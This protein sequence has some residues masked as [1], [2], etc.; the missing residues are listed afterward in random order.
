MFKGKEEI[1]GDDYHAEEEEHDQRPLK[2]ILDVGLH[3]TPPAS[4]RTRVR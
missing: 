2:V 4:R 3:C 1:D